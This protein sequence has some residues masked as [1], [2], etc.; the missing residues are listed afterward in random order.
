[1]MLIKTK[2]YWLF[3]IRLPWG[4]LRLEWQI[5]NEEGGPI[6]GGW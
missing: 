4:D 2:G 3:R 6:K 5:K 1:M